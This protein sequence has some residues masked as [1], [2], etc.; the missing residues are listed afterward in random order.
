[1]CAR[2]IARRATQL[3]VL[4]VPPILKASLHQPSALYLG[5]LTII[6]FKKC[7]TDIDTY[8]YGRLREIVLIDL[9]IDKITTNISLSIASMKQSCRYRF[10][11]PSFLQ[12]VYDF[13][14]DAYVTFGK[15][16]TW[17][18]HNKREE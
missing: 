18:F 6:F 5:F 4:K 8:W 16:L 1:L 17:T 11:F 3:K 14:I 9:E 13:L 2:S 10:L 12:I 15:I 7:T